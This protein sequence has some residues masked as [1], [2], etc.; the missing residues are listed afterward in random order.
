MP[1][2]LRFGQHPVAAVPW[3]SFPIY[4]RVGIYLLAVFRSGARRVE[5]MEPILVFDDDRM[6]KIMA[7]EK[8]FMEL[9]LIISEIL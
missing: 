4:G 5:E 3:R 9:I 6:R 8:D 7:D 1:F 2:P